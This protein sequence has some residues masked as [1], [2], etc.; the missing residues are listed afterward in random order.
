MKAMT[1]KKVRTLSQRDYENGAVRDEICQALTER[2]ELQ[3]DLEK[4][5]CQIVGAPPPFM[6]AHEIEV[7]QIVERVRNARLARQ[8]AGREE[9]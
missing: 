5:C 2:Q 6:S 4:V 9:R 1:V 3:R 7:W 8:A